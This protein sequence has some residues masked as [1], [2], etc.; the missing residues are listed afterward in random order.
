M[1]ASELA[2]SW[3]LQLQCLSPSRVGTTISVVVC[4]CF[5]TLIL[6]FLGYLSQFWESVSK[7]F[8]Y[9][10]FFLTLMFYVLWRADDEAHVNDSF[11][12]N[13]ECY[14]IFTYVSLVSFTVFLLYYLF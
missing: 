6:F 1:S 4:K 10:F 12:W 14:S 8:L 2:L 9:F 11:C 3:A 13:S 5:F 7:S